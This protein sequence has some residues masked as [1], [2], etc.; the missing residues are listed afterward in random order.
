MSATEP[1]EDE[2]RRTMAAL[3]EVFGPMTT[4]NDKLGQLEAIGARMN[5]AI[6][7]VNERLGEIEDRLV[8]SHVGVTAWIKTPNGNA[9]GFGRIGNSWKLLYRCADDEVAEHAVNSTPLLHAS[10]AARIEAIVC[11]PVLLDALIANAQRILGDIE[12]AS[13]K[14]PL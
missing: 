7:G 10:R 9:L 14:V 1:T 5:E 12:A 11:M 8:A 6:D 3:V 2:R 4:T 13:G